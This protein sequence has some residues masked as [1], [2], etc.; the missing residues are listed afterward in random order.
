MAIGRSGGGARNA[1]TLIT[2]AQPG[3][4]KDL[5]G[6]EI[7]YLITMGFRIACFIAV[8]FVPNNVARLGLIA[9]AAVLPAFAVLIAN[10]VDQRTGK[11]PPIEAGAPEP[12]KALPKDAS[13]DIVDGEVID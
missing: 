8:I 2:D 3:R 13:G 6:R 10:A 7:R 9:A 12:H 1:S 5:R 4:S 11:T